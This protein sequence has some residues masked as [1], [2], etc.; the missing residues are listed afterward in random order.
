MTENP[1]LEKTAKECRLRILKAII[2]LNKGVEELTAIEKEIQE[3]L[4]EI[5]KLKWEDRVAL[6]QKREELRSLVS[7][8][9]TISKNIESS[10][11]LI[12]E[13]NDA[14]LD[15]LLQGVAID[16]VLYSGCNKPSQ[17]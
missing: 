11:A 15:Y 13:L 16:N 3:Q 2:S 6:S 12:D 5:R 14:E 10:D 1:G 7:H 17:D 8:W 4:P 9:K